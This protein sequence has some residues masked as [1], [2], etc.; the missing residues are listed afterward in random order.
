MFVAHGT[1]DIKVNN[2]VVIQS[3]AGC[4]NEEAAIAYIED[5]RLKVAPLIGQEWAIMSLFDNWELAVPE[6]GKHVEE[7]CNWFKTNGCI[8][9]CHVYSPCAFKEM[10]LEQL[11][12]QT[13]DS[14]ERQVFAK[15]EDAIAWLSS[16]GFEMDRSRIITT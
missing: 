2:H 7:H 6:I 10:Q 15:V 5:F 8:K 1:W 13:D 14:Y 4:W 9:D 12:P 3:F 11:I 16:C